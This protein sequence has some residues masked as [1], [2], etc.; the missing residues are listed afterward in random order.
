MWLDIRSKIWGCIRRRNIKY[1]LC[2]K[3]P[4]NPLVLHTIYSFLGEWKWCLYF[5]APSFSTI[6]WLCLLQNNDTILELLL[7][8]V[9]CSLQG[10]DVWPA[11]LCMLWNPQ[12]PCLDSRIRLYC[13][14]ECVQDSLIAKWLDW[15]GMAMV[16]EPEQHLWLWNRILLCPWQFCYESALL[17]TDFLQKVFP[18]ICK[19]KW[20]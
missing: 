11:V 16:T 15:G 8:L 5:S 6:L 12:I 13:Y 4:E 1:S 7:V 18:K 10:S 17:V 14:P 20:Y 3:W 9:A 2:G 19:R